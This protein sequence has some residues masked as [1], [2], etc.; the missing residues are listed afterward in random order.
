MC[1]T[2]VKPRDT[3]PVENGWITCPRCRRNHRLLRITDD[4]E[5]HDLRV[6]CRSC[7]REIILDIARGQS[8]TE[9]QSP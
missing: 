2:S 1:L 6:W 9:R 5:A 4:T 3:L 7:R 8:V